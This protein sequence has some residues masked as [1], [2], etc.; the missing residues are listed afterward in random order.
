MIPPTPT[1]V[2]RLEASFVPKR[3]YYSSGSNDNGLNS[4]NPNSS[5]SN[6]NGLNS[7][8]PNSSG[9]NDNGLNSPNP[10]SSGSNAN[11]SNLPNPNSPSYD[12]GSESTDMLTDCETLAERYKDNPEGLKKYEQ[13]RQAD[14][15]WKWRYD[16]ENN[17]PVSDFS[18]FDEMGDVI[19]S[20]HDHETLCLRERVDAVQDTI[21]RLHEQD[22]KKPDSITTSNKDDNNVSV[23]NEKK[24]KFE[25]DDDDKSSKRFKQDSSDITGDTEPFDFCGGDD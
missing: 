15:D 9:S 7:P 24:R 3:R 14:I 20:Q 1:G 22:E 6:D 25:E 17:S 5:D 19:D 12:L 13:N 11:G 8:N 16:H 21:K 4:P 23:S 10:N 18:I 2:I